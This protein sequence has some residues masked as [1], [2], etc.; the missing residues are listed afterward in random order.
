[1]EII[2]YATVSSNYSSQLK[3]FLKEKQ[4]AFKEKYIDQSDIAQK[5]MQTQTGGFLG[6]PFTVFNK[7]DGSRE[8]IVGFDQNKISNILGLK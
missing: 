2:V 5:E 6:V 4:V 7:D 1:M 3:K 8:S